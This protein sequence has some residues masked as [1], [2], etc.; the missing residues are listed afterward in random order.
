MNNEG[1]ILDYKSINSYFT[2]FKPSSPFLLLLLM[3]LTAGLYLINWIYFKNREFENYD[4]DAPDSKRGA[5]LLL[6]FPFT[7]FGLVWLFKTYLFSTDLVFV[8]SIELVGWLFIMF[9]MLQYIYD[10]C[11]TYSR[12]TKTKSLIWYICIFPGFVSLILVPLKFPY[13]LPLL[14]FTIIAIPA[15]QAKLN[16]E[17]EKHTLKNMA[18]DFNKHKRYA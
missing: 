10:F 11:D 9:L 8:T 18:E 16:K 6:I 14:F 15:M 5:V 7:W 13:A 12:F 3:F 17:F 4:E 2:S 1:N